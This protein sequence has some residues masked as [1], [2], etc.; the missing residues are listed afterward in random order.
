MLQHSGINGV[1][2]PRLQIKSLSRESDSQVPQTLPCPY[3]LHERTTPPPPTGTASVAAHAAGR[4]PLRVGDFL[5]H[6]CSRAGQTAL[7]GAFVG[8]V[9][10]RD[11]AR[12]KEGRG[13]SVT[14][15][16][17][18]AATKYPKTSLRTKG[19][20]PTNKTRPLNCPTVA[21][22]SA[23]YGGSP[24]LLPLGGDSPFN[25]AHMGRTICEL[26]N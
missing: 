5:R 7:A 23:F 11:L 20:S 8:R 25:I 14:R 13:C 17:Y 1:R 15:T 4:R 12:V 10:N 19:S 3:A 22:P 9:I 16:T 2:F 18:P 26:W 6:L 24:H 21:A